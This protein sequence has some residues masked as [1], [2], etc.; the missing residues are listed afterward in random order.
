MACAGELFA[1]GTRG[2][3]ANTVANAAL[4]AIIFRG[5]KS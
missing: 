3:D 2:M 4:I 1:Q 5:N